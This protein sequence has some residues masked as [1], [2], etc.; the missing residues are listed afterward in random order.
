M[1]Q[2]GGSVTSK[3]KEA[4]AAAYIDMLREGASRNPTVSSLAERAGLTRRTFYRLFE[5]TDGLLAYAMRSLGESFVS[6]LDARAPIGVYGYALE[7]FRYWE[8]ERL[9]L[10]ALRESGKAAWALGAWMEGAGSALHGVDAAALQDNPAAAYLVDFMFGGMGAVL[11]SWSADSRGP[12][13][14]VMARIVALALRES[15]LVSRG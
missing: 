14:E 4:F 2:K 6:R 10:A 11:V 3:S 1:S 5:S 7:I 9:L 8:G 12:A 13:P 15:P